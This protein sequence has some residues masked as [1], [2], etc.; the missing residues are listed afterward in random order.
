MKRLIWHNGLGTFIGIIAP[1]SPKHGLLSYLVTNHSWY[2][3]VALR[4]MRGLNQK[5]AFLAVC[6]VRVKGAVRY[7]LGNIFSFFA[8]SSR[9]MG[10]TDRDCPPNREEA[11]ARTEPHLLPNRSTFGSNP[12]DLREAGSPL[13]YVPLRSTSLRSD[14]TSRKLSGSRQSLGIG[15]NRTGSVP[16][17]RGSV[18]KRNG[19]GRF[20]RTV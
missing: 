20:G 3:V 9:Q 12:R 16:K 7:S 13:R 4:A 8:P 6:N 1:I 19:S 14:P 10:Q 2:E 18:A 17:Q 11:L 5:N 15:P